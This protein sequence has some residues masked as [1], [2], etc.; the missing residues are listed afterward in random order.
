MT[1][2]RKTLSAAFLLFSFCLQMQVSAQGTDEKSE[3]PTTIAELQSEI[4]KILEETG[5]PAAGVALV[6]KDSIIWTAG[7]GLADLEREIAADENTMFRI[8]STSKMFVSL[9]ILKLQEEKRVSLKDKVRNLIPE[10]E[11]QN[12]WEDTDP[13]LVE[14]LLEHTTG[15]DDI[16]LTEYALDATGLS[17]KQGLDYH[18]HSRSS[19][20]VPGTRMSYCNSGP[21]VA[22]YIVE[23]ITEQPF[24]EY[25]QDNFF[26]PMGMESATFFETDRYRKRGATLYLKGEPQPYWNIILR[27]SGAI[28]ASPKDMAKMLKFLIQRGQVDSLQLI[29]ET[30]LIRMENPS[31]TVGA[32]AGLEN[33]YGLSNYSSP[34]KSFVYQG[35][36]GGVNGG[37]TDFAYLPSHGVGYVVMI[38]SGN[39]G[40][41]NR[42]ATLIRDFQTDHFRSD[43]VENNLG[44]TLADDA[45][46]GYYVPINPRTQMVYYLERIIGIRRLKAKNNFVR[47]NGLLGGSAQIYTPLKNGAYASSE[48]GKVNMVKAK[49]PIAGEVLH[50]AGYGGAQ[51]F[52]RVS[53]WLVFGQ[54]AIL[55]LWLLYLLAMVVFGSIWFFLYGIGRVPKRPHIDLRL[56]PYIT[57][58]LLVV[59][60]VFVAIGSSDPFGILAT[61]GFISISIMLLTICFAWASVWS[62][63]KLIRGRRA[64]INRHV[65]GHLVVFSC[66][67]L[68]VTCYLL[69]H[70]VIG[71][72]LW[73]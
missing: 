28:N 8:G 64:K 19:R 32:R 51:V 23:K 2:L 37:L 29:N 18:P 7:L 9:A 30:S 44:G 55:A 6:D 49:D 67:N 63:V 36:N 41:L 43:K 11:F 52:K 65:Y 42:I 48:T 35:H 34:H 58:M 33:G 39:G 70:G 40:A 50:V 68:I 56:W 45:I 12:P 31:S 24:E 26:Q 61:P 69:W 20:W 13:I 72:Q 62:V 14:Q 27:P 73:N 15:W 66:L 21:P 46:S 16:H 3:T 25:I 47:I 60:Q 5:V 4:E 17:L 1:P 59:A 57:G 22:A 38:N 54:L 71:I 10:I 53:A